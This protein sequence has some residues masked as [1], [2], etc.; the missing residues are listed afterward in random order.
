MTSGSWH[1]AGEG[2]IMS[3]GFLF[4]HHTTQESD[5]T[6]GDQGKIMRLDFRELAFK[7]KTIYTG[8]TLEPEVY[9]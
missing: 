9:L 6:V 1:T 3:K 7:Q 2:K 8:E 4:S 5:K